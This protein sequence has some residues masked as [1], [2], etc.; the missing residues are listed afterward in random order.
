MIYLDN[1]ATS[2]PKPRGM[3]DTMKRCMDLWCGN[4]GR[5]GHAMSMKTGEAVYHGRKQIAGLLG[6]SDPSRLI[7][8]KNTTEGLN[9]AL[10]GF[11]KEGDHVITTSME[12]NSVLRPLKALEQKGVS[13]TI[14][15]A[16]G[17]GRVSAVDIEK[18]IRENTR[19]I[20]VTGASN[21]TGTL[22]PIEEIGAAARKRGIFLLV[23]GAQL[24]GAA[25]VDVEKSGIDMLAFPGHKGLLG[26]LG[27]GGLYVS[28][29][30]SLSPLLCGGTG[31][32]SRE[33]VQPSDFPEGFEAGTLN[34]PGIV[35]LSYAA[36]A[37]A[38]IGVET[39]AGYE[40]EL[41]G[42]L[43]EGLGNMDFVR[44]YGPGSSEK[45]GISLF[46]ICGTECEETAERL[47]REFGIAVR[48]GY[49]CSGLAHK[50]IGTWDTGAVRISVGPF[51]TRGEI[52]AVLDA[53]WKIGQGKNVFGLGC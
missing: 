33:R 9:L 8:T 16:D 30:V 41:I 13:H 6:I 10:F 53:V 51:N 29:R 35:G 15:W 18:E 21:V 31:T 24:V 7:F 48:G 14:V 42:L 19:L 27:T 52:R 38:R 5:S 4:P 37:V 25:A 39:I 50:T 26:P 20:A 23:D 34:A 2:F 45:T 49:H 22:M 1:G 28:P 17:R 12:H 32:A 47:N 11:L 43:D 3:S 44:L 40:R 46:N 36:S